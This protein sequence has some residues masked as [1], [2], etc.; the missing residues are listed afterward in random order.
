M[1]VDTKEKKIWNQVRFLGEP[2]LA[3]LFSYSVEIKGES[4]CVQKIKTVELSEKFTKENAMVTDIDS[5]LHMLENP[6][7]TFKIR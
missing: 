2:S 4:C 5:L 6:R 1:I 3:H 7:V